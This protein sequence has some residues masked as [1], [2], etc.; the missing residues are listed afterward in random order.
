MEDMRVKRNKYNNRTLEQYRILRNIIDK[1]GEKGIKCI[2]VTSNSDKE[3]KTII[4]KNL[5]YRLAGYDKKTLFIDCSL[6]NAKKVE[7][8]QAKNEKGLI[9]ILQIIKKRKSEKDNT[10]FNNDIQIGGL[11][12]E[13]QIDNLSMLPLGL[14][15]LNSDCSMFKTI[16]LRTFIESIKEDFDF[17]IIDAPSFTNLSFTQIIA[18]ATDA[19]L[20]V[21]GE[22]VYEIDGGNDIRNKIESLDCMVLGCILNKAKKSNRIFAAKSNNS[23]EIEYRDLEADIGFKQKVKA[24]A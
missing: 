20:F 23:L 16:Y 15:N 24:E 5:A 3:G 2:N 22:G 11:I 9:D 8:S 18:A 17:I 21:L 7:A 4:A 13:T 6:S 1:N 19:C 10:S 12:K 14:Y